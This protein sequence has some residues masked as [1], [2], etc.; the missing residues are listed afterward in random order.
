MSR[1]RPAESP[2]PGRC[3]SWPWPPGSGQSRAFS[4][5]VSD[6][7]RRRAVRPAAGAGVPSFATLPPLREPALRARPLRSSGDRPTR[8][9]AGARR[10]LRRTSR[11][12]FATPPPLRRPT[13]RVHLL[14]SPALSGTASAWSRSFPVAA[15]PGPRPAL[16]FRCALALA[17]VS[18][19][20]FA[21]RVNPKAASCV[22]DR[23]SPAL[24]RCPSWPWP[25]GPGQSRAFARLVSDPRRRRAVRTA[26]SAG[27]ARAWSR[28]LPGRC[29]PWGR[30]RRGPFGVPSLWLLSVRPAVPDASLPVSGLRPEPPRVLRRPGIVSQVG[31]AC[32]ES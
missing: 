6:P 5:L 32:S 24:G 22:P 10:R 15:R 4:R 26:A 3:P 17:E 14:H 2:A 20:G 31:M 9:R 13:L 25:P 29:A 27:T 16:A 1:D 30:A 8:P 28:P 21:W 12:S 19:R 18:A 7:P 11:P 23:R